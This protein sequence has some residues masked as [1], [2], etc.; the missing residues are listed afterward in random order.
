MYK[1]GEPVEM[2]PDYHDTNVS[3]KVVK[4]IQSYT[5]IVNKTVWLKDQY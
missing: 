3:V 5:H 1:N 2:P 4:L